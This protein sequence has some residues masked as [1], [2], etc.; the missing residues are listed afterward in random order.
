[1]SLDLLEIIFLNLNIYIYNRRSISWTQ[2]PP[3]QLSIGM[4][5]RVRVIG[6]RQILDPMGTGM[7]FYPWS[8][9][10]T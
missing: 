6:T 10:R 9:T 5:I 2:F 7:I 4:I 3:P 1:M 8:G